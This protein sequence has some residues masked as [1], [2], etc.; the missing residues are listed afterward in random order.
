MAAE[1]TA[2]ERLLRPRSV[3]FVGG[4][5]A[6]AALE[7]CRDFG[8]GGPVRAVHPTRELV[9]G[10]RPVR[11]VGDLPE[12]PDAA[13]VAA[14]AEATI[15][16]VEEL[17]AIGAGGAICYAAGFA[18]AGR[19][20]LEQAL[21]DAAG[22]RLALLGPNCYG[23]V[24]LVDGVSLWPAPFPH[25][26]PQRGV[27]L[28]LQ[29]GN[30]GINLTM[31]QRGLDIGWV[32][33][34]GN[35]AGL[36]I[37][38]CVAAL[39][40]QPEVTGIGVYLEGLRDPAAFVVAAERALDRRLPI[41]VVKAGSSEAGS[42]IAATH[43]SSLAG[44]D[45][46][47]DALFD[48]LG[49]ARAGSVPAMIETLK[50]MT[51]TGPVRGRRLAVLT[52][53][54]GESALAA[55]AASAAGLELPAPSTHA[56]A[57]IAAELPWYAGVANPLDFTTALWGLEQPLTSVFSTLAGDGHD[58]VLLVIDFPPD[59]FPYAGDVAAAV[60]AGRAAAEAHSLP[61]AVASVLPEAWQPGR[62]RELAAD[63]VAAL[64]GLEDAF[65]AWAACVRW[66]ER[67]ADRRPAPVVSPL[68]SPAGELLDEADSKRLPAGAGVPLPPSETVA[69]EAAGAAAVRIGFP[70]VAKLVS[71]SL[72][73]K[74]AAGAVRLD[75][76]SAAAVEQAVEEMSAAVAPVRA[77]RVLIERFVAG[78]V[79]ELIVGVKRDPSF[80]PVLVLGSGGNDVEL[81]DDAVPLLLPVS[82]SDVEQAL[83]RLRCHPRLVAGGAD[84]AAVV[85]AVRRIADLADR[86]RDR[87]V[88]LDVNPLLALPDG[89]V[90]VDALASYVD[91]E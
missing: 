58:G 42:E 75:L 3:A 30:L 86:Q 23:L 81:I 46:A 61:Y 14:P 20:E 80:G 64:A 43:T 65:A 72:P 19:P 6:A 68:P 15:E 62:V 16:I 7:L 9:G 48:R 4:S 77:D 11:S 89:C 29:S 33:T 90:A 32:V 74:A 13:F 10:Q 76:G 55:D 24:D 8:F 53:S 57:A 60:R 1:R 2:A 59:G 25:S 70:V 91:G 78:A 87:L 88:E 79:A 66:G 39:V 52:C 85:G 69:L 73:H 67:L 54:G 45:A 35:Q 51:T 71:S 12:P 56:A 34:V 40:E 36:D 38:A 22:D 31:Q 82:R 37:A 44:D 21:R 26:R 28:V 47:Y 84:I 83:V 17:A 50:A 5:I 41:A 18:E 27:A 63:G 49:V